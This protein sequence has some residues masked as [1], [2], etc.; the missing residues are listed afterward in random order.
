[1]F[2]K[3]LNGL[4]TGTGFGIAFVAVCV[5]GIYY[6]LPRVAVSQFAPG[7]MN[8][9]ERETG[10]VPAVSE[11]KRFLGSTA[12]YAGDFLDN[13]NGVLTGGPGKIVGSVNGPPLTRAAGTLSAYLSASTSSTATNWLPAPPTSVFPT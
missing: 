7:A 13:K 4:M 12:G 10:I 11:P 9:D 6:V 8:L 1:M 2:R 5:V 3:F